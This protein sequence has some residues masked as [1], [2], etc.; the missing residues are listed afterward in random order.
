[1]HKIHSTT[2]SIGTGP[3]LKTSSRSA[4]PAFA[5]SSICLALLATPA[6]AIE[7]GSGN[8]RGTFDSSISLGAQ[9]RT[10]SADGDYLSAGNT[11]RPVGEGA[12]VST[13]D[14]SNLNYDRGDMTSLVFKGVHDLELTYKQFGFFTRFKYWYDYALDKNDVNHGHFPNGYVGGEPLNDDEFSKLSSFKGIA[15]LDAYFFTSFNAGA[16]P[17]D[18]RLG[19]QVVSWGESTFIF[20]GI[21]S[22]NPADFGALTRPGAELKEGLLP[23]GMI[24]GSFGVTTNLNIEAFYQYEWARHEIPPCGTFFGRGDPVA[25]GCDALT[26]DVDIPDQEQLTDTG[27]MYHTADDEAR[28]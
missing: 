9:W 10:E 22:A 17:I 24:F 21:N 27:S 7:F 6:Q 4:L 26:L 8:F 13:T 2:T 12:S 19:R 5:L 28:G 1:M 18:L 3:C 14:D 25:Q 16:V 15:L 11:G 23:V 20:G